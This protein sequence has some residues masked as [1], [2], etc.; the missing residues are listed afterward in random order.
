MGWETIKHANK[1]TMA[2]PEE[3]REKGAEKIFE[4]IMAKNF[5]KCTSQNTNIQQTHTHTHQQKMDSE[6]FYRVGK[7][8][9]LIKELDPA[10]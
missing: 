10:L 2:I 3:E 4:E 7:K 5:P 6:T 1:R 8:S 9:M